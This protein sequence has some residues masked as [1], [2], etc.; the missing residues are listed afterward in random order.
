MEPSADK[1]NFNYLPVEF[2]VRGNVCSKYNYQTKKIKT[3][4]TLSNFIPV[5][6][7]KLIF[8]TTLSKNFLRLI[9]KV[10]FVL[11]V[12]A[13]FTVHQVESWTFIGECHKLQ[14]R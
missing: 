1:D 4:I 7:L 14:G 3:T 12:V 6:V 2:T 9:M 11:L 13:V 5:D 8:L 10:A